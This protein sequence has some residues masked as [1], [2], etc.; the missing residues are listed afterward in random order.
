[1][2]FSVNLAT[3]TG[4]NLACKYCYVHNN[5]INLSVEQVKKIKEN[6]P[7]ILRKY[8]CDSYSMTYF[9]GEPLLNF[10]LIK[11]TYQMFKE[12]PLCLHIL[13][14]SNG[15]LLDQE[16][17]DFIKKEKIGFSWS[18]DGLWND[19]NRVDVSGKGTL[20]RYL[21]KM[22]IIR[23]VSPHNCKVM[24][25]PTSV[26]TLVEN[27]EF[28]KEKLN[29]YNIDYTLVRDNIWKE[30][31]IE[32][33]DK[34]IKR[35]SDLYVKDFSAGNNISIGFFTLALMDIFI[36]N[37]L[38]KRPFSCFA[39][40]CGGGF[41]PDGW[42]YACVRFGTNKKYPIYDY[43]N[44]KWNEENFNFLISPKVSNPI[45]YEKCK[46]CSIRQYCNAGCN[47]SHIENNCEP[48]E[49]ICKLF[50]IIYRESFNIF[51]RLKN[52]ENFINMISSS[53]NN[54]G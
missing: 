2:N 27:Y 38:G 19:I 5:P 35:L 11:N 18:F 32:K 34:N 30:E 54:V 48:L 37:K 40:N 47:Y 12:D 31:D 43:M 17:V 36:G 25:S 29:M 15:L 51:D 41:M 14:I 42:M 4:C 1:L 20:S 21:E 53:L 26:D 7:K 13:I 22:D 16:K 45:E 52:N 24:I 33:F 23:Q 9:G 39:G 8:N 6:L 44:D 3:T 50:K 28:F 49:C 46:K 10:D